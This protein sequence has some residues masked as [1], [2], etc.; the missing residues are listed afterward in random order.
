MTS[1]LQFYLFSAGGIVILIM[2]NS[3][4]EEFE[5]IIQNN[6]IQKLPCNRSTG[7]NTK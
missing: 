4:M 7:E 6:Q 2:T 5:I 1:D 3:E